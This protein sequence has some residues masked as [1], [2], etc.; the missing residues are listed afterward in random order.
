MIGMCPERHA[1]GGTRCWR[2]DTLLAEFRQTDYLE[3]MGG[4]EHD[5][6]E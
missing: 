4:R 5:R 3:G 1:S 2:R 6:L